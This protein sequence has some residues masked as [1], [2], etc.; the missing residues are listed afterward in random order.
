[1]RLQYQAFG[2]KTSPIATV[3]VFGMVKPAAMVQN[4]TRNLKLLLTLFID[5]CNQAPLSL[6]K[7]RDQKSL[8]LC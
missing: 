3:L 6:P 1:M 7:M 5:I 2:G 8:T 4:Q